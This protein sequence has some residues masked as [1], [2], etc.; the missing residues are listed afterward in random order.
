MRDWPQSG[1]RQCRF[2]SWWFLSGCVNQ[3]VMCVRGDTCTRARLPGAPHFFLALMPCGKL[4]PGFVIGDAVRFPDIAGRMIAPKAAESKSKEAG[5]LV[6]PSKAAS[7]RPASSLHFGERLGK[8]VF[9]QHHRG[10][11]F[12]R[13]LSRFLQVDRIADLYDSD[14]A[15]VPVGIAAKKINAFFFQFYPEFLVIRA[16][17]RLR[18][19]G[20]EEAAAVVSAGGAAENDGVVDVSPGKTGLVSKQALGWGTVGHLDLDV[21][22]VDRGSTEGQGQSGDD[23]VSWC[24][25]GFPPSS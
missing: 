25:H 16:F 15:H 24:V 17:P 20:N 10:A 1:L 2:C 8:A 21:V 18:T 4:D 19:G 14:H 12:R 23:P 3:A 11:L 6:L 9:A 7:C 22:G 13:F 5:W